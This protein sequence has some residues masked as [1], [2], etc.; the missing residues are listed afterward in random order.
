MWASDTG[1]NSNSGAYSGTFVGYFSQ[2]VLEFGKTTQSELDKIQAELEKPIITLTYKSKNG[3]I[4]ETEK[5]YGT[6]IEGKLSNWDKKY[7]PFSITLTGVKK[8]K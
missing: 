3:G 5:F 4:W 6:K 2:L 1:R 7:E 8:K